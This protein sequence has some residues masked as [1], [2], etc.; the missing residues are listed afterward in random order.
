MKESGVSDTGIKFVFDVGYNTWFWNQKD[1]FHLNQSAN[2][3]LFM[4]YQDPKTEKTIFGDFI[5]TS[6][7]FLLLKNTINET[8]KHIP[9]HL[10]LNSPINERRVNKTTPETTTIETTT[11][12]Q[13]SPPESHGK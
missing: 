5:A 13:T 4:W 6:S 9:M 2:I 10:I 12:Q 3:Y 1:K 11:I 7:P 8:N